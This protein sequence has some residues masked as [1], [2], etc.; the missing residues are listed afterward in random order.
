MV[1]DHSDSNID[2]RILWFGFQS[3][4]EKSQGKFLYRSPEVQNGQEASE[5]SDTWGVGVLTAL[6]LF[7]KISWEKES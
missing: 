3:I 5:K 1:I 2:V 6:L 4:L 7:G